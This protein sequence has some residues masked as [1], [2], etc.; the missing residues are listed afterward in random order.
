M[1]EVPQGAVGSKGRRVARSSGMGV[2]EGSSRGGALHLAVWLSVYSGYI[3]K[4]Y[5]NH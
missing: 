1:T 2:G 4:T 5:E 3:M